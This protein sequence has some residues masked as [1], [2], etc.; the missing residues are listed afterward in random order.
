MTYRSSAGGTFATGR[1][2]SVAFAVSVRGCSSS[3]FGVGTFASVR[4]WSRPFASS[5]AGL[6]D[7]MYAICLSIEYGATK[8]FSPNSVSVFRQSSFR[9][10]A[11][12]LDRAM[13]AGDIRTL[14]AIGGLLDGERVIVFVAVRERTRL[15][16]VSWLH[17]TCCSFDVSRVIHTLTM[18]SSI[19]DKTGSCERS[20]FRQG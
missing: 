17:D 12:F 4:D 15:F 19:L 13:R 9:D 2:C 5:F 18:M 3:D 1:G 20:D 6:I 14:V 16:V 10:G 8:Y 7:L 11:V